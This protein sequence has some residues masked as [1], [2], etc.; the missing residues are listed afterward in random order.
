MSTAPHLFILYASWAKIIPKSRSYTERRKHL[1]RVG[2]IARCQ[3]PNVANVTANLAD[4]GYNA[5]NY[6][7]LIVPNA[8]MMRQ[9]M[10]AS[11]DFEAPSG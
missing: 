11:A 4:V 10:E 3:H 8:T 9:V 6:E 2:V 7:V 5:N 1:Q